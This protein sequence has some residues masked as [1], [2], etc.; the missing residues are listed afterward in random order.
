MTGNRLPE[1]L[2]SFA[3]A[4]I[5]A[6]GI[7]LVAALCILVTGGAPWWIAG[8]AVL[9]GTIGLFAAA[10]ARL[11]AMMQSILDRLDKQDHP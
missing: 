1:I 7:G 9:A 2:E 10:L 8:G 11:Y 5:I 3:M 4:F 6:A